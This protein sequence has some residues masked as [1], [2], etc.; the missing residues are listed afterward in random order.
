[1]T[2]EYEQY[3]SYIPHG[4]NK[5]FISGPMTGIDEWN[6]PLFNLI[7][8]ELRAAGYAV[9]N[10]AEFYDGDTTRTRAEYMRKSFEGL[11]ESEMVFLLPGWQ[12]SEGALV[13]AAVGVQLGLQVTELVPS[14]TL[15]GFL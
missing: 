5:I 14:G 6:H 1:M 13:E 9:C 15:D 11:L 7:A 12:D 10:P 4:V 3:H 8:M 2:S